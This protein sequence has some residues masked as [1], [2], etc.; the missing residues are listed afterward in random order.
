MRNR[1]TGRSIGIDR[2]FLLTNSS[3]QAEAQQLAFVAAAKRNG[4]GHIVKQSQLHADS[5]SPVR[6][7]RYHAVV[8]Q[9]IRDAGIGFTF[10]RANLFMQALL[11]FRDSIISQ[12]KIFAPAGDAAVSV[13]D[14]RDLAAAAAAALTQPGHEGK[15]YALTGPE[16]L[17]HQEMARRMAV[18]LGRPVQFIDVPPEAMLGAVLGMGFPA[19]QAEG[20]IEDY[21]HYA[22]GE[23][24]GMASGVEEATGQKARGFD[25]FLRD[26]AD[27]F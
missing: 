17:S 16:A 27:R 19:W 25:A 4:V 20:L 21:A 26:Y 15:I 5:Q 10:L 22:R 13:V 12:G 11:A 9:A 1:W 6:F 2:A 7:L 18:V 3:E 14:T 24:A 8:E 23:A